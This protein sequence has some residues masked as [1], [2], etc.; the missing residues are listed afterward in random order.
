M[1]YQL[2][3]GL[4][5]MLMSVA[6]LTSATAQTREQQSALTAEQY[7]EDGN[8]YAKEK[9]RQGGRRLQAGHQAQP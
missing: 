7:T 8:K 2:T 9:Q 4:L 6:L 3:I 5:F 1:R